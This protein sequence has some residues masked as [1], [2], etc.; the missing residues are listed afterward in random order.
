MV[1]A[2]SGVTGKTFIPVVGASDV[3]KILIV[4]SVSS[5]VDYRDS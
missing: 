4:A 1:F 5:Q 2:S 3:V